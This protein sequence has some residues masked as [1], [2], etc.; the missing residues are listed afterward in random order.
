MKRLPLLLLLAS[1]LFVPF[2][3]HARVASITVRWTA[4]GDDGDV[5]TASSY[6][7]RWSS[8][9]PDTTY[10]VAFSVWFTSATSVPNMPAPAL[11]GTPQ[12]VVV[13]PVGGF[14]S[15]QTYYFVIRTRDERDN[16]SLLSNVAVR[17]L[18]DVTRPRTIFDLRCD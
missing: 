5:G 1:V 14:V 12:S 10:A 7:M 8:V 13:A 18:A 11:A 15:G 9:P 17:A 2:P 16:V 3:I 6:D 4:P